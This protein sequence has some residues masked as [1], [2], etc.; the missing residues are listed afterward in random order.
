MSDRVS[1]FED[2]AFSSKENNHST[3]DSD[4]EDIDLD[5]LMDELDNDE[6]TNNIMMKHREQRMQE[7]SE[8]LRTV[9][10]KVSEDENFGNLETIDDESRLI[11]LSSSSDKP[12]IIHF[13]LPTFKKCHYMDEQLTKLSRKYLKTKFVRIDVQNSP[14]LV[15][16]LDIKIL[17][18]VIGYIGGLERTRI[19]GFSKLGNDPNSFELASLER[20]LLS[21]RLITSNTRGLFN[22]TQDNKSI[23]SDDDLDI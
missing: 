10:K 8:H 16:K 20:F 6:E 11:K 4:S 13:Q 14:F 18:C 19:V 23:D 17:P 1:K 3:K 22:P 7:I 9:S 21:E 12:V 2:N 5:E 15:D